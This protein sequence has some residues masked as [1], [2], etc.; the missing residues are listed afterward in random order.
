MAAMIGGCE[1]LRPIPFSA[2]SLMGDWIPGIPSPALTTRQ[3][4]EEHVQGWASSESYSHLDGGHASGCGRLDP[5]NHSDGELPERSPPKPLDRRK[6]LLEGDLDLR[7]NEDSGHLRDGPSDG[8]TVP[9]VDL[10]TGLHLRTSNL[11]RCTPRDPMPAPL[12]ATPLPLVRPADLPSPALRKSLF[13][14][15]VETSESPPPFRSSRPTYNRKRTSSPSD[16]RRPLGS[17]ETRGRSRAAKVLWRMNRAQDGE[18]SRMLDER[19]PKAF[20]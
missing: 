20:K 12:L 3:L 2:P 10:I 14:L 1:R 16:P 18:L 5:A 19:N 4:S 6:V 11:T 7:A 17:E 13:E 9:L 15:D 8:D